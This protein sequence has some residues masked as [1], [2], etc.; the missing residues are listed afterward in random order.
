MPVLYDWLM[1]LAYVDEVGEPGAFVSREDKRYNTSP[2]FGYAG[3]VIPEGKAREFGAIFTREKRNLFK[4]EIEKARHRGRWEKKGSDFFYAKA[5]AERP[6]NLRV[7]C[8]LVGVLASFGGQLFYYVD[9]KPIG[10]PRQT[11]LQSE[12]IF[13]REA[14][15]MR[16]S[17]NRLA[18]FAH[19]SDRSILVLMDQINEK[20][21]K[22]RLP[23]MYSHILGR[24]SEHEEMRSIIEPPMHVDS[25]LSS[26]IQFSDWVAACV[27]RAIDY[28][29]I[30]ESRYG[31]IADRGKLDNVRGKFTYESKLHLHQRGVADLN[32]SEIFN[33]SRVLY[34]TPSG[35]LLGEN[36]GPEVMKKFLNVTRGNQ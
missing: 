36:V 19:Q 6:Q 14:A 24:A 9:E 25:E 22:N 29:L 10:T 35:S 32:H 23:V 7:F 2:A 17:L 28:Q 5:A 20:S 21:R 12:D 27:T 8:S 3:F 18:R 4:T 26:N 15:A 31:W 33:K 1:Y 30:K 16:E 11:S 13:E 34:P